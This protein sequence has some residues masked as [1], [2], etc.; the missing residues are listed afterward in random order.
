MGDDTQTGVALDWSPHDGQRTVLEDDSR[1]RIVVAGRRWGKTTLAALALAKHATSH[2]DATCAWASPSYH[3]SDIGFDLLTD[4]L[5]SR[6]I[7]DRTLT[8]PKQIALVGGGTIRFLS[9]DDPDKLR[10]RGYTLIVV[11]EPADVKDDAYH[12][13]LRPTLSDTSGKLLAIGTPRRGTG[14]FA[15]LFDQGQGDIEGVNSWQFA[16]ET[17]PHIPQTEIE[18]A[19][20]ELNSSQF[21]RE[22]EAEFVGVEGGVFEAETLEAAGEDYHPD[23]VGYDS[24][25]RPVTIGLDLARKDDFSVAVVL[26]DDGVIVDKIRVNGVAWHAIKHDVDK[27]IESHS[28]DSAPTVA[29]DATRDNMIVEQLQEDH[30][31][32]VPVSFS[33]QKKETL[34]S[35]L[36]TQ[37]EAG[38]I[39]LPEQWDALMHELEVL[40]YEE[41]ATYTRYEAAPGEKDDTVDALALALEARRQG[42]TVIER[43]ARVNVSHNTHQDND[44]KWLHPDGKFRG[45]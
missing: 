11:D 42:T 39:A 9:T 2:S 12:S 3:Q 38:Q 28:G 23:A 45:L 18:S 4:L 36:I 33:S 19:R 35:N 10:G 29:V 37:V 20:R 6:F 31:D 5:P 15:E 7:D 13:V 25:T 24:A 43:K 17:A 21:A 41:T 26:D 27:L 16:T 30:G 14:W 8:K 34:M 44:R 22:Y 40:T 1:R 32:V